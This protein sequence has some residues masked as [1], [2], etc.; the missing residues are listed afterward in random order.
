MIEHRVGQQDEDVVDEKMIERTDGD[1]QHAV[2]A[3][4]ARAR[5]DREAFGELYQLYVERIYNY[6]YYRV[7]NVED[8]EDLTARTFHKA[9]DHIATY[10]DRGVP[11]SAWLYRI[12]RN[13]VVNWHRDHGKRQ[14]VALDD[15]VQ[16]Q[17]GEGSPEGVLQ[18][19]EREARLVAAVRR[20][21]EDRQELL[22]L[23]YLHQL[24]NAE[25]GEVLGR[26]EGAVKSL[27]HRTL[28]TLREDLEASAE[29]P[30]SP[31]AATGRLGRLG[32]PWRRDRPNQDA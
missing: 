6:I 25:I 24:S 7:G 10:E 1:D 29:A 23:K 27:Y 20:L 5:Q 32:W 16:W 2:A 17:I 15:I 13:S 26:T 12:A 28:Q 21:P 18:Q 9:M 3:L 19:A 4:I 30:A 14:M 22:V 11:F 8:A 31:P